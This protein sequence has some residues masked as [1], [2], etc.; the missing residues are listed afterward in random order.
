M[1]FFIYISFTC[2]LFKHADKF[3][4]SK[5]HNLGDSSL[6]DQKVGIIDVKLDGFEHI[7]DFLVAL[8]M[9]IK[10]I[11]ALSSLDLGQI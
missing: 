2:S 5:I 7:L 6:G 9:S 10:Q 11:F 1:S 8:R 3:L 4:G